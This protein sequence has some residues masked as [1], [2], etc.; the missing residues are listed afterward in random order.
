MAKKKDPEWMEK[1]K[2]AAEDKAKEKVAK[3][4]EEI[5]KILE[6]AE[7]KKNKS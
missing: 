5:I 3:T 2:K 7:K 1:G 6:E 4:Q